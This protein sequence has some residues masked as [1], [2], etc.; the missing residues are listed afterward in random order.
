MLCLARRGRCDSAPVPSG[1]VFSEFR[2]ALP[3]YLTSSEI[4]VKSHNHPFQE[5]PEDVCSTSTLIPNTQPTN[6]A[7]DYHSNTHQVEQL[8][9]SK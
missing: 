1:C 3:R 6:T 2:F 4:H 9:Y 8:N 5:K 7:S